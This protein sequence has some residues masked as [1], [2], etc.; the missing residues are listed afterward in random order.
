MALSINWKTLADHMESK[1]RH[2]E[3]NV[4]YLYTKAGFM[5]A[6]IALIAQLLPKPNEIKGC[7]DTNLVY[8]AGVSL[9]ASFIAASISL[10]SGRYKSAPDADAVSEQLL[11]N[12]KMK[13]LEFQ[14]WMAESYQAAYI[15]FDDVYSK[16]DN[17]LRV[18]ACTT[19]LA[20]ICI[21]LIRI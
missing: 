5:L 19:G 20:L 21:L 4:T 7:L 10:F 9:V 17:L 3:Q 14:K 12:P 1:V 15:N 16:K 2:R 18:A 11:K 13:E 8:I 6:A